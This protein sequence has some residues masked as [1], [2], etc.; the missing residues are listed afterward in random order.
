M[1]RVFLGVILGTRTRLGTSYCIQRTD[2]R[3]RSEFIL[4]Q[5]RNTTSEIMNRRERSKRASAHQSLSTFLTQAANI[6]QPQ[7]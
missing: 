7:A 6:T 1:T 3:Q 5:F 2:F 4:A